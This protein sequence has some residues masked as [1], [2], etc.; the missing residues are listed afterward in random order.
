MRWKNGRL[1]VAL[2]LAG[3]GGLAAWKYSEPAFA[4]RPA[5]DR[6]PAAQPR[7]SATEDAQ[8]QPGEIDLKRSRVYVFVGKS[9]LGHEHA[10]EGRIKSGSIAV[11]QKQKAGQIVFD[12]TTFTS[13]T[14]AARKYVGL[15]GE[16][17]ESTRK[18]VDE[19]MLGANVLDVAKHPTAT[20]AIS[21]AQQVKSKQGGTLYELKGRF[22]LHGTTRDLTVHATPTKKGDQLRLQGSFTIRQTDF[23]ITPYSKFGVIGVADELKI[24]GDIW[25]KAAENTGK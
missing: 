8:P 3:A 18:K 9:G 25:V 7:L 20:F 16:K 1:I 11:A 4:Q 5:G 22:A 17:D 21:S 12:M 15:E 14:A 23:G 10:V 2:L 13:D 24:Y 6:K 19:N